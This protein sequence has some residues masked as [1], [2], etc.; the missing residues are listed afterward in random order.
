MEFDEFRMVILPDEWTTTELVVFDMLIPQGHPG[1]LR[2]FGFPPEFRDWRGKIFVD[3]D[4][5][6]GTPNRDEPFIADPAQAILALELGERWE[7]HLFLVVQT[8]AV[9]EK[10]YSVGTD[11]H[12]RWDEWREDAVVMEVPTSGSILPT[13]VH[14]TQVAVVGLVCHCYNIHT[15]DFG[16]CSSLPL[17]GGAGGTERRVLFEDGADFKFESGDGGWDEFRSS[18]DGSLFC[19]VSCLS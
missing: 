4:R 18:S 10:T 19:L 1:N 8:R 11:F 12:I 16:R 5:D 9:I 17:R 6:L 7:P 14:G 2:R 13:L 3:H 15:F